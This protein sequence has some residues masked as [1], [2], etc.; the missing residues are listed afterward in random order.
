MAVHKV[1]ETET[2]AV[3]TP[4]QPRTAEDA[5]AAS[6]KEYG[7]YVAAQQIFVG[8]ALAYNAGDPIPASNVERH[9]YAANGLAIK[10]GTKA[11]EE[12]LARLAGT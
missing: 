10:V 7:Q 4:E 3:P 2:A 6:E 11:A 5:L 8:T 1:A 9:G 12:L